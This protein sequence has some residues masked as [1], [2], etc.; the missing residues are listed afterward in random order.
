[1]QELPKA[2]SFKQVQETLHVVAKEFKHQTGHKMRGPCA[3]LRKSGA[4]GKWTSNIQRDLLRVASR[5]QQDD[6]SSFQ[7]RD[8][9]F[10]LF[11]RLCLMQFSEFHHANPPLVKV[12]IHMVDCPVAKQSGIPGVESRPVST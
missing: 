5:K 9:V 3:D 1:M 12:P 10:H 4:S 7:L 2:T 11:Y 6:V 8:Q